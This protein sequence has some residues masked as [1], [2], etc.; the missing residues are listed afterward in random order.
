MNKT[1]PGKRKRV[2]Q[3]RLTNF[4]LGAAACCLIYVGDSAN[5]WHDEGHYYAAVAATTNLPDTV[6]AFFRN[7][8]QTIGHMSIDPDVQKNPAT[9]QLDHTEWCEHFFDIEMIGGQPLPR[10]RFEYYKLCERLGVDPRKTGTLPYAVAEWTQ[11]LTVAF[12]EHRANPENPYIK[13]K[14]L[15]YAGM[16]SH[17]TAD[18]HMPLHTTIHFDGIHDKV[19]GTTQYKGIHAQI[20]A[21]P[22]KLPYAFFFD[23]K[24][25][26]LKP[27]A[28]I[29]DFTL[30]QFAISHAK[31]PLAYQL[32]ERYPPTHKLSLT[33]NHVA[34]FT[35]ERMRSAA[36]FTSSIYL[37]AWRNSAGVELPKW[38]DRKVFDDRFNPNRLPDEQ[39]K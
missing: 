16:L 27:H 20:D 14:C 30:E 26:A 13:L 5:A 25:Q 18:L 19:T 1:H 11:R 6:P 12:A 37:S 15:V 38:L 9:P 28:D 34:Q 31:V 7:G 23:E 24:L 4:V 2:R 32:A 17:Y 39:K 10:K 33:D 21:L 3:S 29:F 36:W 8:Y 35:R 22:S